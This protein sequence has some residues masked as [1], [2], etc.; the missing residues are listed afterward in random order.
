VKLIA[1]T[2]LTT[3]QNQILFT[4]V[5]QTFT[6]LVLLV[7]NRS[8]GL[9]TNIQ[10]VLRL[11]GD[12]SSSNY[13]FRRLFGDGVASQSN[14]GTG[15]SYLA[16]GESSAGNSTANTFSNTAIYIPNYTSSANK[17][18]LS[19]SVN[20]N[21]ATASF[22]VLNA[23]LWADNSAITQLQLIDFGGNN[24]VSG[25]TASLYGILK[26]SDGIVTTS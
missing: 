14:S 6:D 7:S 3:A 15:L 23:S 20:E 17:R 22:Q 19:D 21:N 4:S 5:P 2:T 13:S 25:S 24:F 8:A 11:N 16:I 10:L 9:A 12:A 1:T 26:G 18:L